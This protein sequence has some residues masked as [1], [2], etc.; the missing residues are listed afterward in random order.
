MKVAACQIPGCY[1]LI[2]RVVRDQRGLFAKVFHRDCFAEMGLNTTWREEYYSVSHRRVLRGLHFQVPPHDHEKLVYC[3]SGRV[4]DAVVDLRRGS[5][6]YGLHSIRELSSDKANALYIPRGL[7]HG[8][9]V[10]SDLAVMV[11]L[12]STVHAPAYDSGIHWTSTGIDWPDPSPIVSDRDQKLPALAS[13]DSPFSF[14]RQAP[15]S[16]D[17]IR[18][19][20][21]PVSLRSVETGS[22]T[23]SNP[24]CQS[25]QTI[26][27]ARSGGE[28]TS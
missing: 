6:T 3:I 23:G 9:Y 22:W 10:L 18:K 15:A 14:A 24:S 13:F 19:E 8:F 1:E 21:V 16:S 25:R 11:Y 2:A 28:E 26:P 5:P 17:C 4:L 27:A 7:A 12:V 20:R